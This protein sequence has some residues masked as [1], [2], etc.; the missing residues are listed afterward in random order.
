VWLVTEPDQSNPTFDQDVY[1]NLSLASLFFR[2]YLLESSKFWS[3]IEPGVQQTIMEAPANIRIQ[4]APSLQSAWAVS[5]L[6][7]QATVSG[8]DKTVSA[9][10]DH[11][12]P[13]SKAVFTCVSAG[14]GFGQ[15]IQSNGQAQQLSP[16]QIQSELSSYVGVYQS[17]SDCGEKLE[18]ADE[19]SKSQAE[20][21][22]VSPHRVQVETTEDPDWEHAGAQIEEDLANKLE[23]LVGHVHE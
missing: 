15:Q 4:E 5:S 6:L 7:A 11:G 8:I 2:S 1:D 14:Y 23:R 18:A 20:V 22:D 10:K 19:A 16:Q 9:L 17:T 3:T 13:L 21:P 12:S